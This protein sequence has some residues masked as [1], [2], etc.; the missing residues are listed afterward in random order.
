M[1]YLGS[2]FKYLFVC[3]SILSFA[4]LQ[5]TV[6]QELDEAAIIASVFQRIDSIDSVKERIVELQSEA[7]YI[8]D[9][10]PFTKIFLDSAMAMARRDN[11]PEDE[12]KIMLDYMQFYLGR[13]LFDSATWYYEKAMQM[14]VLSEKP[15]IRSDFLGQMATLLK[16][17]GD[18]KG[19]IDFFLQALLI[20]E[21]PAYQNNQNQDEKL[22]IERSLC[23]LHNNLANLYKEIKDFPSANYHYDRAY[24]LLLDME[25]KGLAGTVL[26]NKGSIYLDRE[27][28]D[29]AYAIQMEAKR[30]KQEGGASLRSIAM[31]DL[32]I[33]SALKGLDRP[34]EAMKYVNQAIEILRELEIPIGFSDALINRGALLID[35]KRYREGIS[36]CEQGFRIARE[37]QLLD[38]QK[39]ACDCLYSGYK[40]TGDYRLALQKH[41][42]LKTLTDSLRNDE[43]TKYITQLEMQYAFDQ[44]EEKRLLK[45]EAASLLQSE[46][47]KRSKWALIIL[48][49]L[50]ASSIL[51]GY[52]FYRNF[53]IKKK[54]E[55]SLSV[56]NNIIST[57]LQDKELLLRE[58]H[59]RVKNN[60]Q[61]ISSLL[62]L[63]SKY[64]EDG[65]AL[66]AISA[67][68]SRVH[69]MALLHEN[70][71]K[72]GNLTGIDM[73]E[74]FDKLIASL[75][76]TLNIRDEKISLVKEIAPIQLD[77]DSVVPIGLITNELITNALKHAFTEQDRG[78]LTVKLF[79]DKD[80]LHLVVSDNGKGMS[81]DVFQQK[82]ASFGH[83]LIKT[84][85]AKLKADLSVSNGNGTTVSFVIN[86]YQKVYE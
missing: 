6:A 27:K 65:A 22:E 68:R 13:T 41:E 78:I 85:A 54:A 81:V 46:K 33:S 82:S 18:S 61:V 72:D 79:E 39:K 17:Q 77:V 32:N 45:E 64:I 47:D 51:A 8:Y 83:R 7:N 70:L 34:E 24:K 10:V 38:Q 49:A 19:A 35:E 30:L 4:G 37:G 50:L 60:L 59:H 28:Y 86:D 42:L 26:M 21:A 16:K 9:F 31:S 12:A 63:Q 62:R 44:E 48:S 52:L 1:K 2:Y 75:F 57:A 67:G 11:L 20:L 84:F 23:V 55:Q 3:T 74:Y 14:Q 56:K 66:D 43:N 71:Y 5:S 73:Q 53:Q 69:S 29:T 58:I 76:T 15:F 36:D 40:A 25:E 80:H